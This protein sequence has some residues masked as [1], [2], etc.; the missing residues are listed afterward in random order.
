MS[1]TTLAI[2]VAHHTLQNFLTKCKIQKIKKLVKTSHVT[3]ALVVAHHTSSTHIL[4]V[5]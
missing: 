4:K 5:M 1:H 3:L 2:L